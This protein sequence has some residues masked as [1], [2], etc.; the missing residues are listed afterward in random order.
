M[1]TIW[2]RCSKRSPARPIQLVPH[3]LQVLRRWYD[4]RQPAHE[5]ND[6]NG[7]ARNIARHYDLS[8]DLFATFLDESMSYSAALFTDE[9][10]TLDQAQIHKVERLLDATGVQRG[11]PLARNRYGMG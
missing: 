9:H 1:P 6:P 10:T 4:A 7:A 5:D 2:S 3:A 8:N 11:H